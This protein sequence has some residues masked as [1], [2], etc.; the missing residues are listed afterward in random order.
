MF[1]DPQLT[2]LTLL[3][4]LAPGPAYGSKTHDDFPEGDVPTLPYVQV[5]AGTAAVRW[6]VLASAPIRVVVWARSEAASTALA[7]RLLGLLLDYE[8]GPDMRGFGNPIGPTPADDPDTGRP[9]AAFTVT[10][11]LRPHP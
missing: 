3:R 5:R 8:G 4:A 9:L 7:W 6:P 2:T 1:A 11:R 10:A